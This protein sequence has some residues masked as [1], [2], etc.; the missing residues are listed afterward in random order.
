MLKI[1]KVTAILEGISYL[2]L[3]VNMLILKSNN[4]ELYHT[5]VRP[6]GIGHG[7]LFIGYII[8]GILLRKSQ[9]WDL[10]TFGII[11]IASLIPFGTFYIEKKYLAVNA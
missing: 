4:P 11:L 1:F 5:I 3:I 10:K 9:N 6:F 8:L 2:V 7:V